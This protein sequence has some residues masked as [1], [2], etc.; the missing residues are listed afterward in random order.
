[1]SVFTEKAPAWMRMLM[2]DFGLDDIGAAAIMG[3]LGHESGGFRY[4]QEI[5]PTIPGSKGGL[6]VAQ[7]TGPRRREF[8]AYCERNHLDPK[9]DKANYGYLYVE[10]KGSEAAAIPAVQKAVGL[11]AKVAAF[12][13]SFERAGVINMPSRL[14]YA[15][16]ALAAYRTSPPHG[17]PPGVPV[18]PP[19]PPPSVV[20]PQGFWAKLWAWLTGKG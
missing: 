1:M 6:G 14:N 5:K 4:Y 7:W 15:N 9:S 19:P 12:E 18:E 2:A 10:L 3:N 13:R 20:Q 11:S 16:Q 17:M 8:E